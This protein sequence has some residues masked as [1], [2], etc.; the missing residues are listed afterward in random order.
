MDIKI[1]QLFKDD[2]ELFR[3]LFNS[4]AD[5]IIV[6][7]AKGKFLFFNDVAEEILGI[8][9]QE[10][11]QEEWSEVYGCFYLDRITPFP[12]EQLPLAKT[13][14]TGE[15]SRESVFIKNTARPEII[16]RRYITFK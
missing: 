16:S 4:I 11:E 7:D 15:V 14:Q 9:V 10:I 12:S 3:R 8:S 6:A 13:I 1:D 5:G 2:N